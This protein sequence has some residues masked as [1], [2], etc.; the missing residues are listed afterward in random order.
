MAD[1]QLGHGDVAAALT[2]TP[3][4]RKDPQGRRE[5]NLY[6]RGKTG[7]GFGSACGGRRQQGIG[8]G[9]HAE[10]DGLVLADD[11]R[12]EFDV[13]TLVEKLRRPYYA[14]L[15]AELLHIRGNIVDGPL[16]HRDAE[17]I[18]N[19]GGDRRKN[20][21]GRLHGCAGAT[22]DAKGGAS[23]QQC[24][25]R[26]QR[27][28]AANRPRAPMRSRASARPRMRGRPCH[29]PQPKRRRRP[30]SHRGRW[31]REC[32]AGASGPHDASGVKGSGAPNGSGESAAVPMDSL[33]P[34]EHVLGLGILRGKGVDLDVVESLANLVVGWRTLQLRGLGRW[35]WGPAHDPNGLPLRAAQQNWIGREIGPREWRFGRPAV[36]IGWPR[37]RPW[38]SRADHQRPT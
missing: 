38:R 14:E 25:G 15:F 30:V 6:R 28:D 22:R 26:D 21:P 7:G 8:P 2:P 23:E 36:P 5:T 33:P 3:P 12:V 34:T 19:I 10:H 24:C 18:T 9:R 11:D 20:V 1:G 17:P 27:H 29:R 31:C 16:D 13:A 4:G 37:P 32:S 35:R